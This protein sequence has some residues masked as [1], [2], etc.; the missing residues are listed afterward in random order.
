MN[1]FFPNNSQFL[2]NWHFQNSF[3]CIPQ[4]EKDAMRDGKEEGRME[5]VKWMLEKLNNLRSTGT[6]VYNGADTSEN[7]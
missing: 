6:V 2:A 4:V 3:E 7:L 5:L 1:E